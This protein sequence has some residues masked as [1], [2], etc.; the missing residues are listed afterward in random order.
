MT[1]PGSVSPSASS[2][3]GEPRRIVL[4]T[5]M[6][7]A[8]LSVA[9]KALEDLGYEAVDNLRLSLVPALIEQG[10]AGHRPLAIVVDSRTRDFD[11]DALLAHL[12]ALAVRAD[13]AVRLLFLDCGD[14]VLQRRFTET[15]RRHPLAVDRPVPDGIQRERTLLS[16]L[17]GRADVT[18][19]TTEL[20]I[21]EL[22]RLLAG[23]FALDAQPAL[24]VFITSFSFR[25]GL[26]READLVFDVRFLTNPHWDPALRPLS[27]LDAPVAAR[28]ESDPDFPSFFRNLTDL[29]RP[30]LPRYN[31]EG[32]SYLT[33]AVG[34]TGGRH[35][36]VFVAERL[37]AW[38]RDLGVRVG[39]THRDLERSGSRPG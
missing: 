9:L 34:C 26:P 30:L 20:S 2:P 14:E 17:R 27:G 1:A 31:Q 11:A 19:D 7:G 29:L 21:H 33:I 36:S 5:G 37:A 10:E 24:Q 23:H 18:I 22:R 16:P 15:R 8:G 4:I 3:A 25:A 39:L 6:S 13:V 35:R 12:D 38:L 32:K 28:V